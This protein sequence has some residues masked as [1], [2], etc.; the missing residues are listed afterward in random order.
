MVLPGSF[1]R[2]TF[3]YDSIRLCLQGTLDTM[4]LSVFMLIAIRVFHAPIAL[5]AFL[6]TLMWLGGIFA[7]L[8]IRRLAPLNWPTT[9]LGGGFFIA[10]G[11]CFALAALTNSFAVYIFLVAMASIAYRGKDSVLIGMYMRNYPSSRMATYFS[12]GMVLSSLMGIFF[13]Q[14]AGY[15]LD[16]GLGNYHHLMG[17]IAL[18][19][20][21]CAICLYHIPSESMEVPAASKKGYFRYLKEDK[22]FARMELFT[23]L[24]GIAFQ[25]LVPIRMEYLANTCYGLHLSNFSVMLLS[26]GILSVARVIST[27]ILG[28]LFDMLPI[29]PNQIL[30]GIFMLSGYLIFFRAHSFFWLGVSAALLGMAIAGKFLI[31]HFWVSRV[32]QPEAVAACMSVH[33]LISGIRSLLAPLIGYGILAISSP[34]CV[35]YVGS[36]LIALGIW[37]FWCMRKNPAI[38]YRHNAV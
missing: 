25:M 12:F 3:I 34:R 35:A 15:V 33:V 18:C 17:F 6:S 19:S 36:A 38:R 30:A 16:L 5:K 4:F 2:R 27:P 10:I 9:R 32:V 7:P 31:H 23:F 28:K 26:W 13:G 37:G 24:T 20:A 14:L 22:T 11:I 8:L 29:I 21:C 1:I